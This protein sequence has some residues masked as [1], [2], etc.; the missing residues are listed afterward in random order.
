MKSNMLLTFI[1]IEPPMC[2]RYPPY[3]DV[4]QNLPFVLPVLIRPEPV[5]GI[6]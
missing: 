3:K 1:L 4:G 6:D 5:P 2:Q